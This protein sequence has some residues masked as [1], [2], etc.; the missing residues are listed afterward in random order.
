LV[1]RAPMRRALRCVRSSIGADSKRHAIGSHS[2]NA[3]MKSRLLSAST[4]PYR[5]LGTLSCALVVACGAPDD[6][7]YESVARCAVEEPVEATGSEL[8]L[9][10]VASGAPW[11]IQGGMELRRFR[12]T[13]VA[14]KAAGY[15]LTRVGDYDSGGS[16]R[17]NAS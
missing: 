10:F 16:A 14:G 6:A 8:N 13:T 12:W 4:Y 1:F 7:N 3:S 9:G 2:E 15:R 11:V 5:L 17:F